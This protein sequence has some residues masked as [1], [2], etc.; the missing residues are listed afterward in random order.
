MVSCSFCGKSQ[1]QVEKVIAGPNGVYICNECVALCDDIL[2]QQLTDPA[3]NQPEGDVPSDSSPEHDRAN[4][5]ERRSLLSARLRALEHLEDVN[6][7][8]RAA[9]D[10]REAV[11]QLIAEPFQFR[12]IEAQTVLDITVGQQT[13]EAMARLRQAIDALGDGGD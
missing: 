11:S 12:E 2:D 8:V 10:R 7:A 5:D 3:T 6:R 9:R 13:V 4:R 1:E